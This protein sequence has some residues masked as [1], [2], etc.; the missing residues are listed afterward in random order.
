MNQ[1]TSIA[2][3]VF[4]H[5]IYGDL[6]KGLPEL[7]TARTVNNITLEDVKDFYADYYVAQLTYV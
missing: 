5:L 3:N 7:G 6:I 1:P 2:D 4:A